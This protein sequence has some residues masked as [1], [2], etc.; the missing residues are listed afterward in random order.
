MAGWGCVCVFI[1]PCQEV[2]RTKL[3]LLGRTSYS[4][5]PVRLSGHTSLASLHHISV[6]LSPFALHLLFRRT[7][8]PRLNYVRFIQPVSQINHPCYTY[9]LHTLLPFILRFFLMKFP[10]I[11]LCMR[12]NGCAKLTLFK[13]TIIPLFYATIAAYIQATSVS[14]IL[15]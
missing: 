3:T 12:V 1:S 4:V 9:K 14:D 8:H 11:K 15:D 5:H 2:P 13:A 7:L 6:E 10:I